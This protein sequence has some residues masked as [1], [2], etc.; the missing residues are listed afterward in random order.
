MIYYNRSM[1][2]SGAEHIAKVL[3]RARLAKGLSQRALSALSGVP[4]SHISK[5]EKG[6]VDLRLSSLVELAR[7]LG[8]EVMLVPRV[9]VPAVRSVARS[10]SQRRSSRPEPVRPMYSLDD[11]DD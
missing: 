9:A 7:W 5:I 4:Q 8:M 2:I 6:A 3:N 11:D 1:L 10:S